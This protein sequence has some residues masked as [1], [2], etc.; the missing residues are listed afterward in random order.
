[1]SEYPE[2]RHVTLTYADTRRLTLLERA[3]AC[4]VADVSEAELGPLLDA[5]MARR[6]TPEQALKASECFYAIA[7][8]LERRLDRSLTWEEAESWDVTLDLTSEP[9][10][11]A[12]AEA[13]TSVEASLATGLPPDVAGEITLAQLDAYTTIRKREAR[14]A[15]R[16]RSQVHRR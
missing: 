6:A 10:P 12:E 1:M 9:D 8:Q 14:E 15:R 2:P 13:R 16:G 4:A 11:I 3:R 7:W 5:A